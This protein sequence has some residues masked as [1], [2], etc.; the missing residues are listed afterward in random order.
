MFIRIS[1]TECSGIIL[2]SCPR[3]M[4]L[5]RS[6]KNFSASRSTRKFLYVSMRSAFS[7]CSSISS[8]D[9]ML[10]YRRSVCFSFRPR[11]PFSIVHNELRRHRK[12]W[13][14][15]PRLFGGGYPRFRTSVFKSHSCMS[16]HGRFWLSSVQGAR[17]VYSGRKD[18]KKEK[19][20]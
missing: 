7:V 15:S 17:W 16:M 8:L 19:S 9:L 11:N 6:L 10:L 3:V 20:R 18:R 4:L 13:F 2:N 12:R 5:R 1:I 14:L